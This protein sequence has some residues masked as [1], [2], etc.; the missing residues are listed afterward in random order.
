[1]TGIEVLVIVG[2]GALIVGLA[3]DVVGTIGRFSVRR[4]GEPRFAWQWRTVAPAQTASVSRG[5]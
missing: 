1:M 2:I 4:F 3:A 5:A